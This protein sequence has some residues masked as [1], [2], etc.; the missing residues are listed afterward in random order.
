M[1]K[2]KRETC[3]VKYVMHQRKEIVFMHVD[4]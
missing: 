4:W 3:V 1:H 2:E